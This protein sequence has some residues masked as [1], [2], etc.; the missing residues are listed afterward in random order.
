LASDSTIRFDPKQKLPFRLIAMNLKPDEKFHTSEPVK[1]LGTIH[2]VE[3]LMVYM[4][5]E[6]DYDIYQRWM[7]TEMGR[8]I[9]YGEDQEAPNL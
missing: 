2:T 6:S 4:V 3:G 7:E 8:I 9:R 5:P 1:V